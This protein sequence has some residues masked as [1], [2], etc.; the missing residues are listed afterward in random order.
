MR[1]IALY[2][3]VSVKLFTSF[4]YDAVFQFVVVVRVIFRFET[5]INTNAIISIALASRLLCL[6]SPIAD[7]SQEGRKETEHH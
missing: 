1:L 4:S 5:D 7:A 6:S 3:A 2:L